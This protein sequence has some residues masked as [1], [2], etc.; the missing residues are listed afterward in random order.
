MCQPVTIV[1]RLRHPQTVMWFLHISHASFRHVVLSGKLPTIHKNVP[2]LSH[3]TDQL[4][5]NCIHALLNYIFREW[6][7]S[8]IT[9]TM[10]LLMMSDKTSFYV[11]NDAHRSWNFKSFEIRSMMFKMC[12]V[13]NV[14]SRWR[15]ENWRYLWTAGVGQSRVRRAKPS[16]HNRYVSIHV[17]YIKSLRTV[18]SDFERTSMPYCQIIIGIRHRHQQTCNFLLS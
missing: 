4:N 6:T 15:R 8:T 17:N 14:P 10:F 13:F 7:V 2:S 16:H 1:S 18:E 3:K 12:G 11:P 5:Q 9:E